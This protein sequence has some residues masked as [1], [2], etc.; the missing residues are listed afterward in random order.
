[1][2]S[3]AREPIS[4]PS[5]QSY[6]LSVESAVVMWVIIAAILQSRWEN[7]FCKGPDGKYFG[8]CEPYG[9]GPNCSVL[10]LPWEAAIDDT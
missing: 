3:I 4:I 5:L 6:K 2:F 8:L 10:L 1:M 9:L 7:V